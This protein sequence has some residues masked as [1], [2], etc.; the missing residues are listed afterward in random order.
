MTPHEGDAVRSGLTATQSQRLRELGA[1]PLLLD[2]LF[3]DPG[4]RDAAFKRL[5]NELVTE[6]RRRLR[7]LRDGERV[8]PLVE[9]EGDLGDALAGAGFVRVVTPL[10]ITSDSL[11]KMGIEH[12][13]PL[14]EQV[15][16]LEDGRCLRP[17]LAPNLYTL[18]R[19]LGRIWTKPFGIFEIGPCFRRDSKGASHL[20]EFTMLNL[21][22][23]GRPEDEGRSRLEEL[24]GMVMG[25][26]GIADYELE[27]TQSEV[28][29]AMVDV[30]VGGAEVCSAGL[31]PN[32]L[33]GNW[34]IVDPWVGLGFG[35]E[36]L[37]MTREGYPN[38][39]RAGRSLS[40]VDGVRLNI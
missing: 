2:E 9:L 14:R 13:H 16:W 24:A 1:D 31:G 8:P 3:A 29:G 34:G 7:E 32:P 6:G 33:D 40:Y 18:L 37:I 36:R 19:R 39:E 20:N 23:L 10:I 17:M 28:Y 22:E 15:F 27:V 12:G 38:I 4:A 30:L 35:L 26:A 21:V 5:E 25:V 11:R